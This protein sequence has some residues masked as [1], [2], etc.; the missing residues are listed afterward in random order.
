MAYVG[1]GYGSDFF[2]ILFMCYF[3]IVPEGDG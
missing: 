1:I 3:F 2:F